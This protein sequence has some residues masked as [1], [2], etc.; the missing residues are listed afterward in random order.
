VLTSSCRVV[1]GQILE[2]KKVCLSEESGKMRGFLPTSSPS[3]QR[4]G[5]VYFIQS[6]CGLVKI[7]F[8]Y[9]VAWD[10]IITRPEIF[11]RRGFWAMMVSSGS[12]LRVLTPGGGSL[13]VSKGE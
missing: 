13:L 11:D 3:P 7:G 9:G 4:P 12:G 5:Y 6:D 1:T 8:S 2:T 10:W